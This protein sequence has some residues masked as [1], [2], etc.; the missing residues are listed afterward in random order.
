[1]GLEHEV[2]SKRWQSLTNVVIKRKAIDFD[3][4]NEVPFMQEYLAFNML[5]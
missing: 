1:M 4:N 2:E 5:S 3:F